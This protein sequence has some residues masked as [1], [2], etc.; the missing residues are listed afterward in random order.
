MLVRPSRRTLCVLLASGCAFAV[1]DVAGADCAD[2]DLS[3]SADS[4]KQA[5]EAVV[6][7]HNEQRARRGLRALRQNAQLRRAAARHSQEMVEQSYFRH[8]SR[9]GAQF[10]ERIFAARYVRRED[11]YSLGENLAWG[12][13]ELATPR[14]VV[15]A[16]MRSPGHRVNVL[17]RAYRDIGVGIR[18]GVPSDAGVGA[19]YTVD[20]GARGR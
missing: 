14:A 7:L 8:E 4:L 17:R 11:G 15:A 1:P 5:R 19:T 3:P 18:L 6:C 16:W 9:D 2:A 10:V 13:G 20:F 12:T